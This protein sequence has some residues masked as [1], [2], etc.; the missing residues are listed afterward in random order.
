MD[1]LVDCTPRQITPG[2]G[3]ET[4]VSPSLQV[5]ENSLEAECLHTISIIYASIYRQHASYTEQSIGI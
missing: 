4:S 2:A 5:S 3:A 1:S